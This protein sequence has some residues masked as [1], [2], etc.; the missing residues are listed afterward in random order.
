MRISPTSIA[1]PEKTVLLVGNITQEGVT[2]KIKSLGYTYLQKILV[3][4]APHN[5]NL[6]AEIIKEQREEGS[7]IAAFVHLTEW[8]I[9][10][11]TLENYYPGW[12][13]IL[14]ELAQCKALVFVYED[15]LA[16]DFNQS[17]LTDSLRRYY[18]LKTGRKP[19]DLEDRKAASKAEFAWAEENLTKIQDNAMALLRAV[20]EAGVEIVPYKRRM[21]ITVRIQ[22]YLDEI[23]TGVL[24]R[25]Y[26]PNLQYQAEQLA[27][28]IRLLENYLRTVEQRAFLVD[29]HKAEHGLVYVFRSQDG[30]K[31]Q[32]LSSVVERFETFMNLC[33]N[34]V[35]KARNILAQAN[36]QP[37]EMEHLISKY[38]REYRRL[39]LDIQHEYE[40]KTLALKQ[41]LENEVLDRQIGRIEILPTP[42]TPD[43]T[44]FAS[45]EL[46][47]H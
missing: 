13:R 39:A 18:R 24:L 21:Q 4:S 20:T 29:V 37:A 12:Q 35:E 43:F 10:L 45:T 34:D 2:T 8:T 7:L 32:E 1:E 36:I 3:N 15:N 6:T 23:E 44:S 38:L 26:V 42:V 19:S 22:E 41:R 5:W 16:G 40:Q 28:L 27:S 47:D 17:S 33:Q 31:I 30:I 25:L 14:N 46:W 9:L 11:C